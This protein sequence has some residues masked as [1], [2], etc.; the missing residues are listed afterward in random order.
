MYYNIMINYIAILILI[1][2]IWAIYDVWKKNS[3]EDKHGK[4]T[5]TLFLIVIPG[6]AVIFYLLFGKD[7]GGTTLFNKVFKK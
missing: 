6:I 2:I 1:I 3:L 4:N 5:W 7:W